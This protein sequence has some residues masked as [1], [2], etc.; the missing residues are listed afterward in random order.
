[1]TFDG[2][3]V[4]T[5]TANLLGNA[6]FT[7]LVPLTKQPG[8]Y[9][10]EAVGSLSDRTG[11]DTLVV[12][13]PNSLGVTLNQPSQ[14]AGGSQRVTVTNLLNGEKVEIRYDGNLVSPSNAVGNSAGGY[15]LV[16]PVGTTVGS[17]TVEVK[18]TYNGRTTTKTFN[19]TSS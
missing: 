12:K 19:V 6:N 1:V 10:V 7:M 13:A 5:G 15:A 9:A 14:P 8:S 2:E 4:K 18:G 3:V 11:T 17:H 16:F